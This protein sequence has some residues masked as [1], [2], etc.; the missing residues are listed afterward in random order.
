MYICK[1]IKFNV[2]KIPLETNLNKILQLNRACF[3]L[4]ENTI[5]DLRINL[6]KDL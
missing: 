5:K 3:V 6:E 4:V 2:F 1:K